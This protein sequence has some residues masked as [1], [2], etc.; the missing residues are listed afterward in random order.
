MKNKPPVGNVSLAGAAGAEPELAA[1]ASSA[2]PPGDGGERSRSHVPASGPRSRPPGAQ[3][4][5]AMLRARLQEVEEILRAIQQGEI[6]ALAIQGDGNRGP[7]IHTLSGSEH[8]YWVL[9]ETMSEGAVTLDGDGRTLYCNPAFARLL[10]QPAQNLIGVAVQNFIAADEQPFFEALL[11]R[12]LRENIKG[13]LHLRVGG[14]AV[15]VLMSFS[16]LRTNGLECACLI[17]TDLRVQKRNQEIT[18]SARL[19]SSI[20]DQA[21]EAIIVCDHSGT[22]IRANQQAQSLC[23]KNPLLSLFDDVF[24]LFLVA[25]EPRSEA[26]IADPEERLIIQEILKGTSYRSREVLLRRGESEIVPLLLSAG[27]LRTSERTSIGCVVNLT[28]ITERKQAEQAQALLLLREQQARAEAQAANQ[29][30][31][32]FLATLSHELRT[33]LNAVLGWARLLRDAPNE[34]L[35]HQAIEVIERNARVQAQLI[36]DI[37]DISRI[38]SGKLALEMQVLDLTPVVAGAIESARLATDAKGIKLIADLS[39][40]PDLVLGDAGRLQQVIWNLLSNATK[41]TPRG[42]TIEVR[43][44]GDER[45]VTVAVTDTGQGISA[46]F[47]PFVFDRFRQADGSTTRRHGGLGLGLAIVRHLVEMHGGGVTVQSAGENRGSTFTVQ[48]PR[49]AHH[50]LSQT[51]PAPVVRPQPGPSG[52]ELLSGVRV[53][54]VDDQPDTLEFLAVA[55]QQQGAEVATAPSAAAALHQLVQAPP[56][57][58]ISDIAMPGGDG[59]YL[60]HELRALQGTQKTRAGIPAIALTAFARAADAEAALRAGFQR[61]LAKPVDVAELAATVAVLARAHSL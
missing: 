5:I 24:A 35:A 11:H 49:V 34:K 50:S 3:Q 52:A 9:V 54:V 17:V 20:L 58:L 56:D 26:A 29:A 59:Y 60:V 57:V 30:K 27:P 18:A 19:T 37:L 40:Q 23:G 32:I 39:S 15:P 25:D 6:D 1:G 4:E 7:Q 28:D 22:I 46:D 45:N 38:V 61:H 41:F 44:G 2:Q 31:D 33:P 13:E 14:D 51:S 21:A 8:P 47:L 12:G 16:A 10:G 48:L 42:G 36:D 53:L 43:L 55:L